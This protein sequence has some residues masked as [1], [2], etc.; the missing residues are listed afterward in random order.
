ML[1]SGRAFDGSTS[2][3]KAYDRLTPLAGYT[4]WFTE[5]RPVPFFY[6]NYIERLLLILFKHHICCDISGSYASYLAGVTNSFRGVSM[7]IALQD[8]PLLNLIFQTGGEPDILTWTNFALIW[9]MFSLNSLSSLIAFRAA[10]TSASFYSVSELMSLEFAGPLQR[11]FRTFRLGQFRAFLFQE[12]L[13][14]PNSPS[15]LHFRTSL[16]PI[17]LSQIL[18]D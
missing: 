18:Q 13:T 12:I 7:C 8:A 11:R 9:S 14:S 1:V 17:S 10:P 5:F 6:L 3:L 16:W 15:F 4:S 2:L